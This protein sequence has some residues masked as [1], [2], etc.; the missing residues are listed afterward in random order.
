LVCSVCETNKGYVLTKTKKCVLCKDGGYLWGDTLTATTLPK[1]LYTFNL[2][3][4]KYVLVRRSGDP[5]S[6]TWHEATDDA[7]GT[8]PTHGTVSPN[9]GEQAQSKSAWSVKYDDLPWLRIMFSTGDFSQY[10]VFDRKVYTD[11]AEMKGTY[12]T[13]K[14]CIDTNGGCALAPLLI[15]PAS[16]FTA[17]T[18]TQMHC[19][20]PI[21]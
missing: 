12:W 19:Q 8:Q 21:T 7:L 1:C 10:I 2:N 15:H 4:E 17:E 13:S 20:S 11:F 3:G 9:T 14:N 5:T 16:S 6:G 18:T